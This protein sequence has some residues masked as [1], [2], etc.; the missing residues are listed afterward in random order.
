MA[1]PVAAPF[2][3]HAM[4]ARGKRKFLDRFLF[5]IGNLHC[6]GMPMPVVVASSAA[7]RGPAQLPS[8]LRLASIVT[9]CH[10]SHCPRAVHGVASTRKSRPCWRAGGTGGPTAGAPAPYDEPVGPL[11]ICAGRPCSAAYTQ[12]PCKLGA[13]EHVC[14]CRQA[15]LCPVPSRDH[16]WWLAARGLVRAQASDRRDCLSCAG[17]TVEP[18]ATCLPQGTDHNPSMACLRVAVMWTLTLH[19]PTLGAIALAA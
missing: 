16:H 2:S 10:P 3:L 14:R 4:P 8:L 5:S 1:P 19:L 17:G 11:G 6:Y 18:L 15:N 7:E 13:P 9:K 12:R